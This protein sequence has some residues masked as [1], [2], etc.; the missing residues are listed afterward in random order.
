M[1][2][3]TDSADTN[4]DELFARIIPLRRRGAKPPAPRSGDEPDPPEEH[5]V[6]D[7]PTGEPPLRRRV[8]LDGGPGTASA[9]TLPAP[10]VRGSRRATAVA[11][12]GAAAVTALAFVLAGGVF[13]HG[14]PGAA[15]RSGGSFAIASTPTGAAES[16]AP[17]QA[18]RS[19][20][21][22]D[23]RGRHAHAP[24]QPRHRVG[25]IAAPATRTVEAVIHAAPASEGAPVSVSA[26]V[27]QQ[28]TSAS[29]EAQRTC[30]SIEFG[31]EH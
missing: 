26:P 21:T 1:N 10:T 15:S 7:P 3:G 19:R 14:S 6:W 31:I 20:G 16:A 22:S 23:S 25:R 28:S 30:A 5:S 17:R 18:T 13:M 11:A 4:K 12:V 2:D 9:A 27:R 29:C 24:A 8:P